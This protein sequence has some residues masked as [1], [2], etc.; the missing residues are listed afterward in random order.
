MKK[1]LLT[2]L[3]AV[4]PL[5]VSVALAEQ[6]ADSDTSHAGAYVK[7]SVITG[8]VKAKLAAK[9]MF[10][11][12]NIKVDTDNQGVVWLSGKAPTKDASDLAALIAKDTEGV[13][14]VHNKIEVAP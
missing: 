6:P 4:S 12:T 3:V 11:L 9:H 7:D 5:Y 14:S 1:L 13:T 8:K 2:A 10:T